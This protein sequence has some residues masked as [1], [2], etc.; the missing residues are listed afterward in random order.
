MD[1]PT[2]PHNALVLVGDGR[3][4]RF[5]RNEGTAYH[6]HFIV[7][8]ALEH[9]VPPTRELGTDRPGR[10]VGPG[11]SKSAVDQTDRHHREEIRFIRSCREALSRAARLDATMPI[12]VI[13]P[14]KALGELRSGMDKTLRKHVVGEVPLDLTAL[15]VAEIEKRLA[16]ARENN[17]IR[18]R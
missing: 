17:P 9:D 18:F 12:V 3:K 1:T 4:A 16:L 13:L 8:Q 10:V 14:P 11:L 6:P 2:V 5:L 15:T 7:Q